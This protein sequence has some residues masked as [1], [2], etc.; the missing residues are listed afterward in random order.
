VEVTE[1]RSKVK[2]L[3]TCYWGFGYI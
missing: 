2:Q 1:E 3:Y